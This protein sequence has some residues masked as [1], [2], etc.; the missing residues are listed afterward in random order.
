MNK[1]VKE[2][3]KK[4]INNFKPLTEREA[5]KIVETIEKISSKNIFKK[6]RQIDYVYL[7]SIFNYTLKKAYGW[8]NTRIARF[9]VQNGYVGYD[10]AT[11]YHSLQMFPLYLQYEPELI[12]LYHTIANMFD[13][14]K[15]FL[16][17][18]GIK[19]EHLKFEDLKKVNWLVDRY[20]Y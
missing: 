8:R 17:S 20:F 11:V 10:H 6:S 7:R 18:I 2:E 19:M 9:Y 14:K 1:T 15:A 13:D 12:N 5:L 4:N 3:K 16:V